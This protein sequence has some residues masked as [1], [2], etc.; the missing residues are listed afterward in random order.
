MNVTIFNTTVGTTN[1]GDAIIYNSCYDAMEPLLE[2]ANVL[3][4]ATHLRNFGLE[5]FIKKSTKLSFVEDSDYK[6]VFGTNILTTDYIKSVRQWPMGPMQRTL[7]ENCIML[8]VGLTKG[9]TTP[10]FLTKRMYEGILRKDIVHSVRDDESKKILESLSG[11]KAINTGC[12][13]LWKMTQEICEKIPQTKSKNVVFSV[14]GYADQRDPDKDKQMIAVLSANYETLYLWAQ[15]V[16]DEKYF[17][18]ISPNS[19]V[20]VLHTLNQFKEVCENA[21]VDYVG[22]RLHGGIFA[23]QNGVRSLVVEIDHRAEGF[24][25]DNNLNTIKRENMEVLEHII[26]SNIKTEIS[27]NTAEIDFWLGQF[28]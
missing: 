16:V 10:G 23:M 14:S 4:L 21:D 11:I 19:E 15:T 9:G 25:I 2:Q 6:F 28:K 7:Y 24:R 1:T 27:L 12:P 18:E 3:E 17:R 5:H 8:G 26:N 22:T 13:T 20:K